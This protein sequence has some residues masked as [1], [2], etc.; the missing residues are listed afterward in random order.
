MRVVLLVLVLLAGAHGAHAQGCRQAL[1]IGLDVSGSVDAREYRLQLDGLAGALGHP[2]VVGALMQMP[3][4][5]VALAVYEWSGAGDQRVILPWRMMDGPAA[6]AEVTARLRTTTRQPASQT[7][8]LGAALIRGDQL[9]AERTE[10]WRHTLDLT[11]D[12]PSNEG[13]RPREVPQGAITVNALV[14][15][16]DPAAR[17]DHAEADLPELT[18]YFRAEVIRGPDA[19]VETALGFQDFEAAMVRKLLREMQTLVVG[20]ADAPGPAQ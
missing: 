18:T 7:T 11:G 19:F 13:P 16:L 5:P 9:L 2:D 1:A 17:M 15:G 3:S 6:L 12:G 4:A 20:R 14:I 10:C 8:A